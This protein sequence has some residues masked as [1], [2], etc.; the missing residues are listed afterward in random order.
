MAWDIYLEISRGHWAPGRMF[1]GNPRYPDFSGKLDGDLPFRPLHGP[2]SPRAAV[3]G[4]DRLYRP[5]T[6][7]NKHVHVQ[8]E[9][10]KK[11]AQWLMT[12]DQWGLLRLERANR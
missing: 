2:T 4:D 5:D 11:G 3:G 6:G 9:E 1:D 8:R 10:V 12:N 7:R